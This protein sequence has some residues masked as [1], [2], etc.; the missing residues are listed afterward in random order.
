MTTKPCIDVLLCNKF[1]SQLFRSDRIGVYPID[2]D[3][4]LNVNF[5][6][7]IRWIFSAFNAPSK[8]RRLETKWNYKS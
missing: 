7:Q 6:T 8:Y 3:M 4:Q 5:Y 1:V 2:N